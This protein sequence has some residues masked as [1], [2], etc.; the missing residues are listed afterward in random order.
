MTEKV[1]VID[2]IM[3]GGKTSAMID[4][5]NHSKGKERF[6]YITPYLTEVNRIIENC[7]IKKFRQPE[8]ITTKLKGLKNLLKHQRNIVSTHAM[9]RLLDEEC[10]ELIRENNY[11]L[12]LDEVADVVESCN[13]TYDDILVLIK[14]GYA[15][16]DNQHR[17]VWDYD[18]YDGVLYQDIK[19]Q[20]ESGCLSVYNNVPLWLFPVEVFQSF[21]K[22]F[23]LTYMFSSQIQKY[24]FDYNE[25]EYKYWGV[26]KIRD[27]TY[28]L[29]DYTD[30]DKVAYDYD[31]LVNIC[32]N[33]KLNSI[34]DKN[35][36][37]SKNWYKNATDEEMN[38]LNKNCYNFIRNVAHAKSDEV[39]WT[40][41]KGYK[42]K[43]SNKGYAKSWIPVNSRATN[44]YG[45]RNIVAYPVNRY[46]NPVIKNFF[47]QNGIQVDEEG[48]AL[49][50]MVQFIWRSAIRSGKPIDIY[51]P[52][53]RMRELF[54]KWLKKEK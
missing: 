9:F 21:Q 51:I 34:G 46:M 29:C 23:I 35:G 25:I 20:C 39:L 19:T 53:K 45:D 37:L 33:T 5:I 28:H 48:Y 36:S 26:E 22:V 43:I 18:K 50:E 40:T 32:D 3:G 2:S 49:S 8:T 14:G 24:Y 1:N 52:S 4:Y 44:V 38:Q 54:E 31:S 17:L 7:A 47:L 15:H 30:K 10:L 6:L 13:V 11:I 12:I 42:T 41:F 27:N 16:L